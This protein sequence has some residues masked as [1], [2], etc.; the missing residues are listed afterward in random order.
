VH[1]TVCGACLPGLV[2][3]VERVLFELPAELVKGRG[4]WGGPK[5]GAG[6]PAGCAFDRDGTIALDAFVV[7]EQGSKQLGD[8]WGYC[9]LSWHRALARRRLEVATSVGRHAKNRCP[10]GVAEAVLAKGI[11]SDLTAALQ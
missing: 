10:D 8:L 3:E 2:R 1:G 6:A 5:R 7:R 11:L 9:G 4:S